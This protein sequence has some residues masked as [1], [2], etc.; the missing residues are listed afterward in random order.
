MLALTRKTGESIFIGDDVEVVVLGVTGEQVRLGIIAP[1]PVPVR[2]REIY[3]RI[4]REN[5]EA[6]RTLNVKAIGE[7]MRI[8]D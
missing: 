4:R 3:R 6:A 1:K 5:E 2:R 8:L 7:A